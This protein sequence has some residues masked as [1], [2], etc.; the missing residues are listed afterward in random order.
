MVFQ[1]IAIIGATG[2]VGSRIF[3]Q[4]LKGFPTSCLTIISRQDSTP[5]SCPPE[6]NI[7]QVPGYDDHAAVVSA[8]RNHDILISTLNVK[9]HSYER[10]LVQACIA[11]G[12]R[13]FI[14]SEFTKDV[15]HPYYIEKATNPIA[16]A[17]ID[18]AIELA[19][20]ANSGKISYTTIVTG[21]LIDF[22]LTTGF[23]GFDIRKRTA[24]I[25]DDGKAVSTGSGLDFVGGCVVSML[26]M[27]EGETKN[28]RIR[29]SEVEYTGERL[30]EAFE[31][32]TGQNWTVK[33]SSVTALNKEEKEAEKKGDIA[34][35]YEKWVVA[36]DNDGNPSNRFEDGLKWNNKGEYK[37]PRQTLDE[38]VTASVKLVELGAGN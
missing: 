11:A 26:K 32:V 10:S 28:K 29:I 24:T 1:S 5:P 31:R 14:P 21:S 7:V 20:I 2:S 36:W 16:R 6:V 3:A 19:E 33:H 15:L 23:W 13:R 18:W 27:P 4:L 38:L 8:L 17:R 35:A 37:V 34:E 9:Y 25:Y 22:C 30:V 12:V